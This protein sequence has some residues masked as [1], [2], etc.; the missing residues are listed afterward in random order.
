MF[1]IFLVSLN[2]F[3]TFPLTNQHY[4]TDKL[5]ELKILNQ[6]FENFEKISCDNY[7]AHDYYK[8]YKVFAYYKIIK[9]E[10]KTSVIKEC[11]IPKK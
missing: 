3:I 8:Y 6:N 10:N 9:K 7:L 11:F 2:N 1:L 5:Q 4:Q